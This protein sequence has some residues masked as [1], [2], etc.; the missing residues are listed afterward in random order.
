MRR[1]WEPN[2]AKQASAYWLTFRESAAQ[3]IVLKEG[4]NILTKSVNIFCPSNSQQSTLSNLKW[5][6]C[7]RREASDP[8][9]LKEGFWFLISIY[10]GV[11]VLPLN[12]CSVYK[13]GDESLGQGGLPCP[14]GHQGNLEDKNLQ[15][16]LIPTA[17]TGELQVDMRPIEEAGTLTDFN[18]DSFEHLVAMIEGGEN[19][20]SAPQLDSLDGLAQALGLS[21]Q[22]R[23]YMLNTLPLRQLK[24]CFDSQKQPVK[25]R[26]CDKERVSILA[27]VTLP[28][29][30]WRIARVVARGRWRR[31]GAT[32]PGT[33]C[34]SEQEL[35]E[36]DG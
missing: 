24:Q 8:F 2:Q 25:L 34:T 28:D 4:T 12:V 16:F 17:K 1:A 21:L 22:V 7:T 35:S 15:K 13:S 36:Q 27:R 14:G 29:D 9:L 3:Q 23:S 11:A 18:A 31:A 20:A 30:C 33:G 5:E 10:V 32:G 26:W 6:T 19:P